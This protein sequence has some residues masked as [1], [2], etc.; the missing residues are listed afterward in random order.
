MIG[1]VLGITAALAILTLRAF[2]LTV[3]VIF[4]LKAYWPTEPVVVDALVQADDSP[5]EQQT[6]AEWGF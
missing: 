2:S 1:S 6:G 3:G 4:Q 5:F